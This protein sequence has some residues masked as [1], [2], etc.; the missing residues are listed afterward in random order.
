MGR[1]TGGIRTLGLAV[2]LT[3]R[4][5]QRGPASQE[6]SPDLADPAGPGPG[7]LVFLGRPHLAAWIAWPPQQ[8]P[9]EAAGQVLG[10]PRPRTPSSPGTPRQRSRGPQE[11]PRRACGVG[12]GAGG[13][14]RPMPPRGWPSTQA[15]PGVGNSRAPG[16]EPLASACHRPRQG[17]EPGPPP[18]A[19]CGV[20]P[21]V[22]D[23]QAEW[24]RG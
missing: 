10:A 1:G 8:P 16:R 19:P 2:L 9:G 11:R 24:T 13:P 23:R 17:P 4:E 6:A 12:R 22:W 20:P 5:K 15:E 21:R 3:L 14:E 18:A 7:V